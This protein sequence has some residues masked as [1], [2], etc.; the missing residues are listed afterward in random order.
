MH[1]H[2]L[3]I[4]KNKQTKIQKQNKTK[5]KTKEKKQK[6]KKNKNKRKQKTKTKTKQNKTKQK[7]TLIRLSFLADQGIRHK[8]SPLLNSAKCSN[9]EGKWVF[10]EH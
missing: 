8:T 1:V 7:C 9:V 10:C 5:T 3:V 2:C 6:Q 4:E